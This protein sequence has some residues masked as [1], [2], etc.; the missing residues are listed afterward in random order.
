MRKMNIKK[1]FAKI[2]EF[3]DELVMDIPKI[4]VTGKEKVEIINYKSLIEYEDT[5]IRINTSYKVIKIEGEGLV[6]R[7]ISDD[8]LVCEGEITKII[9]E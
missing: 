9:F 6:I 1:T 2:T 7:N 4:S 3:P 5:V 8:E